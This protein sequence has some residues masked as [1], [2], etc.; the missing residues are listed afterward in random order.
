MAM[1]AWPLA[2]RADS[3]RNATWA[4]EGPD[5]AEVEALGV[6]VQPAA[7]PVLGRYLAAHRGGHVELVRVLHRA[8]GGLMSGHRLVEGELL[9]A[10]H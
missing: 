7:C 6:H 10:G 4:R 2:S 5:P 8:A 9:L 1:L 3:M